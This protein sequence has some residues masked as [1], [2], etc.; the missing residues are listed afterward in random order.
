MLGLSEVLDGIHRDVAVREEDDWQ[1][2][3]PV[4]CEHRRFSRSAI[5][6]VGKTIDRIRE[7]TIAAGCGENPGFGELA[8]DV[9]QGDDEQRRN[10]DDASCWSIRK[11][12]GKRSTHADGQRGVE[13]RQQRNE[14]V[15]A[16]SAAENQPGQG[17]R[18]R[19]GDERT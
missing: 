5:E 10:R 12:G 2:E 17:K 8:R 15:T 6:I 4:G 1:C 16:Q 9:D 11:F 13:N 14:V 3:T 18:D 7:Q 19:R